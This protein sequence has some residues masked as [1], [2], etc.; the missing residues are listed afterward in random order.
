METSSLPNFLVIGAAK[1]GTT[2]LHS[3]LIRHPDVFMPKQKEIH[4]FLQDSEAW[5]TWN[6]GVDWYNSLF[7]SAGDQKRRGEAS[8]GYTVESQTEIA[9]RKIR[10]VLGSP[11][12][13]Y[14]VREPISR[15]QSHYLESY[16]GYGSDSDVALDDIISNRGRPGK[17]HY[18][19]YCDY[20]HT[21]MYHRQLERV[22]RHHELENVLVRAQEDFWQDR[23]KVMGEVFDF[24]DVDPTYAET[25]RNDDRNITAEKR[26]RVRDPMKW[27]RQFDWYP[28]ISDRLPELVKRGYRRVTSVRVSNTELTHI[29]DDNVDHLISVMQQDAENLYRLT[30][31]RVPVGKDLG[32]QDA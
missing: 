20:V 24:L 29:S 17:D 9:A 32:V 6:R 25:L 27:L 15:I 22:L 11:R 19:S 14:F 13:I 12:L 1:C 3:Y 5:G 10:Q 26:K 30:G 7:A 16:Y 31:V 28:P 8:P 18:D 23:R 4:F 21:S 2:S